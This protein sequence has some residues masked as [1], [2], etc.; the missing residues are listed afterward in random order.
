[1]RIARTVLIAA[2]CAAVSACAAKPPPAPVAAKAVAAPEPPVPLDGEYWGTS[3]RFRAERRDCPHPGLVKLSV[4]NGLFQYR[5]N[6]RT[7]VDSGVDPDDSVHGQAENI[8]LAGHRKGARIEGDV[9]NGYCGLHFT[10]T[11]RKS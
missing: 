11:R 8:T 10:V 9:T 4:Q 3:T 1:M 5:W 6:Y 7:F 2:A